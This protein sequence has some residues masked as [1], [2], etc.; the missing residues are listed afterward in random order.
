MEQISKNNI[1]L[2][3]PKSLQRSSNVETKLEIITLSDFIEHLR[4]I[5]K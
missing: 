1:C 4:N 3:Q 2:V 5:Q